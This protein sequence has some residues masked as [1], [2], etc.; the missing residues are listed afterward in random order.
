MAPYARTRIY[1]RARP[2]AKN[3]GEAPVRSCSSTST[4]DGVW[5]KQDHRSWY[6]GTVTPPPQN[7]QEKKETR[8][9]H[10]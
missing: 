9:Q 10:K 6:A 3:V 4:Q 5:G 8:E 1:L 2:W 7:W